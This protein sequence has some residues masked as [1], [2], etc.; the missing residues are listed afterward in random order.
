MSG[1]M[2]LFSS[3]FCNSAKE[4]WCQMAI[5]RGFSLP[6]KDVMSLLISKPQQLTATFPALGIRPEQIIEHN[7]AHDGHSVLP[8]QGSTLDKSLSLHR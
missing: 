7:E 1:T 3:G 5:I 2:D 8:Y 6:L 4:F